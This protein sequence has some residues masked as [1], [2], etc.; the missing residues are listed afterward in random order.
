MGFDT[1]YEA[2]TEL[3]DDHRWA[4]GTG[5]DDPMA[6]VD[7]TVPEGVDGDDLAVYCLMLGDDALVLSHRL[8]QWLTR[9]PELEEETALANIGLDLLGQARWLL[10]R[11]G[12]ADGSGRSEDDFAYRRDE[13]D[14][15]NVRL[16]E[17][18]DADFG[19]LIARLFVFSTWRLAL[20]ARLRDSRDPVLAAVADQAV[21]E[22][23]YHR[24]YAAQWVIRLG[25]GTA[26]SHERIVAG[27]RSVAPLVGE[28][29]RVSE[30]ERR[31]AE[32]EVAV[33]PDELRD[34][35]DEVCA[36]VLTPA[37]LTW[38]DVADRTGVAGRF[39]RDG[40]HS[41]AMGPLLAELQSIA[42]A[43]PGA[44]W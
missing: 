11:A 29:F 41:E 22:L 4:Y 10:A 13:P 30:V 21:K 31:L 35:F 27:L 19:G 33:R 26:Y 5:F 25:D 24:E 39:G 18:I 36:A 3:T 34:E 7:T 17:G 9:A 23:A 14:F 43:H 2:I 40:V 16:A 37:T 42:R 32:A 20:F 38:P 15:R 44:R 6:G 8:Q 12:T 28:L 1:A